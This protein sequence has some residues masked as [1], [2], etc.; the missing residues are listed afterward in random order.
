MRAAFFLG[1]ISFTLNVSQALAAVPGLSGN[2]QLSYLESDLAAVFRS[3]ETKKRKKKAFNFE[4]V[5]APPVPTPVYLYHEPVGPTATLMGG[6][7]DAPRFCEGEAT[8]ISQQLEC[9]ALSDKSWKDE[10]T[11][12]GIRSLFIETV[13]YSIIEDL[14]YARTEIFMFDKDTEQECAEYKKQLSTQLENDTAPDFFKAMKKAKIITDINQLPDVFSLTHYYQLTR[15]DEKAIQFPEGNRTGAYS[16]DYSGNSRT[17]SW[18]GESKEGFL[19]SDVFDS[20]TESIPVE[21]VGTILFFH[22]PEKGTVQLAAGGQNKVRT[23][24]KISVEGSEAEDFV[25]TLFKAKEEELGT[26]CTIEH[27]FMEQISLRP[28]QNPTYSRAEQRTFSDQSKE[29]C[30]NY[31]NKV[32]TE[33]TE[34]TAEMFFRILL[35]TGGIKTTGSMGDTF[36]LIHEYKV[37]PES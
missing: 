1:L 21:R 9:T 10:K 18:V 30:E 4:K 32:A 29:G 22:D 34:G 2:Y 17:E 8:L 11:Q 15:T 14:R 25:C 31:R 6:G 37:T 35:K 23:C 26:G 28:G 3:D 19:Q 24:K 12:C 27:W 36:K 33:L 20:Q 13:L 5:A 16:V 7:S